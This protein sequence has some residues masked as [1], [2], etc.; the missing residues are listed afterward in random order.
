MADLRTEIC[1]NN[2]IAVTLEAPIKSLNNGGSLVKTPHA[3]SVVKDA[4][5]TKE[6]SGLFQKQRRFRESTIL[7]PG[8]LRP[9]YVLEQIIGEGSYGKVYKARHKHMRDELQVAIKII[10]T[11]S[12]DLAELNKEI[13]I[14]RKVGKCNYIVQYLGNFQ[15]LDGHLWIVM[16]LCDMG[17]VNDILTMCRFE[18][19][20]TEIADVIACACLGLAHLHGQRLIHRDV[21]CANIL[22]AKRGVAKLADFGI[23]TQVSTLLASRKTQI[24]TP[25]W[26]APEVISE[27]SYNEKCDIWSLGISLIEIAEGAPPLAHLHPMRAVFLIPTRPAPALK[28]GEK[29]WSAEMNDFL[30]QC[31][32]KTPGDRVSARELLAHPFIRSAV[33]RIES[34]GTSENIAK[35]ALE[36][37][38]IIGDF[39]EKKHSVIPPKSTQEE[40]DD[41]DGQQATLTSPPTPLPPQLQATTLLT[42]A[43]SLP[44]PQKRRNASALLVGVVIALLLAVIVGVVRRSLLFM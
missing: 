43:I 37:A 24:G 22:L 12:N 29:R 27:S 40:E 1:N 30:A 18:F 6:P 14:L 33:A 7:S 34:T 13:E 25:F 8:F 10:P 41:E 16:D 28:E 3:I 19:K 35:L 32:V 2:N 38:P 11:E 15:T 39:L 17:S 31:L 23:S 44:S 36:C 20:E 4:T 5:P 21:K 9:P 26:M 42:A